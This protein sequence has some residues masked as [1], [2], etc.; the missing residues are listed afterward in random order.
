MNL[1]EF[2]YIYILKITIFYI[3]SKGFT[4]MAVFVWLFFGGEEGGK[5]SR[6]DMPQPC[7]E[8]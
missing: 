8:L 5:Y 1:N 2:L 7:N 6:Q 3:E 4:V